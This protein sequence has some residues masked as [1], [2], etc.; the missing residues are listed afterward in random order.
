MIV[1]LVSMYDTCLQVADL[2]MDG[3]VCI[4]HSE[5]EKH[6]IMMGSSQLAIDGAVHLH[7]SHVHLVSACI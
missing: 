5:L 2:G 1:G 6:S 3:V 4:R 7:S